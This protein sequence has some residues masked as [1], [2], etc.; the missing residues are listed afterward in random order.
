MPQP[1]QLHKKEA[2][3][4]PRPCMDGNLPPWVSLQNK[5]RKTRSSSAPPYKMAHSKSAKRKHPRVSTEDA[6]RQLRGAYLPL[7]N[8]EQKR[9]PLMASMVDVDAANQFYNDR[10]AEHLEAIHNANSSLKHKLAE[11]SSSRRN[12]TKHKVSPH[13][14]PVRDQA[15]DYDRPTRPAPSTRQLYRSNTKIRPPPKSQFDTSYQTSLY[16][17]TPIDRSRPKQVLPDIEPVE[18][19]QEEAQDDRLAHVEMIPPAEMRSRLFEME[20]DIHSI[21]AEARSLEFNKW[22]PKSNNAE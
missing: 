17:R 9:I 2:R 21:L 7:H 12:W 10:A 8:E 11:F 13:G 1:R 6:L 15:L 22:E 18:V 19:V 4:P 3:M 16:I 5:P 14:S 20:N